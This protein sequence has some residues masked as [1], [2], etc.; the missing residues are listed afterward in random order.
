MAEIYE[1][2]ENLNRWRLILGK[3]SENHI[4]FSGSYANGISYE[5]MENTLD[6]LYSM[7]FG[8]EL[9]RLGGN[10]GSRLYTADWI[11]KVRRIFPKKTVEILE[12]QA[13]E[14]FN[15]T[16][17]LTDKEI[18]EKMEPNTELLKTILQFKHM[19]KDDV[20]AEAKRIIKKVVDDITEKLQYDIKNRFSES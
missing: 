5:D 10:G 6:F 7:E 20:M 9:M 2:Q 14:H 17:M 1:E 11:A 15:L 13:L 16:E 8:D 12:K 18:L 4:D 19:M 3:N